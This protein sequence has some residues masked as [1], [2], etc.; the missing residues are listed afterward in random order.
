[1]QDGVRNR[2]GGQGKR[3]QRDEALIGG[4]DGAADRSEDQVELLG[5]KA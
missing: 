1:M 5:K 4:G 2:A 3:A